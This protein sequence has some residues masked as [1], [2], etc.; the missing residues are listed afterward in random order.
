M[1]SRETASLAGG[2][3]QKDDRGITWRICRSSRMA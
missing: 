2:R 1:E 3:N